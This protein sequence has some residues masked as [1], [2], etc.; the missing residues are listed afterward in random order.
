[1]RPCG[2]VNKSKRRATRRLEVDYTMIY[3]I[4]IVPVI[5]LVALCPILCAPESQQN[6]GR[7]DDVFV[8]DFEELLYP[9]LARYARIQGA[10]VVRVNLDDGGKVKEAVAIS[11]PTPLAVVALDNVRKWIFRPNA[12]K[13]AVIV[14]NFEILEGRCKYDQSFFILRGSTLATVIT[15]PPQVDP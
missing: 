8:I 3:C 1:M 9:S 13:M 7:K 14:Y 12:R 10:V 11:G 15:C 2:A 5:L 6:I 4:R